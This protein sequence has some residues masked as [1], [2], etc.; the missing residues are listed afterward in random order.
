MTGATP[1]GVGP[2]QAEPVPVSSLRASVPSAFPL[3][4][5]AI[6]EGLTWGYKIS[7]CAGREEHIWSLV[8]ERGGVHVSGWLTPPLAGHYSEP[9]W[10]GGIEGHSPIPHEYGS[11]TPSHDHCWLIG[12]PC[13][14]DGSSLQFSEQ[15][16]PWLP[17]AGELMT[18]Y[19]H[20]DVLREMISR[21][22]SWLPEAQAIEARRAATGT[23]AVHES[24]V[25]EGDAPETPLSTPLPSGSIKR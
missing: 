4:V 15:L 3:V 22:H 21:Y 12:G 7:L 8:G 1:K 2:S 19:H 24:A 16:A 13:W 23:G 6:P 25:S 11:E 10:M 9:R 14:H 5:A 20:L 17:S 18:Q